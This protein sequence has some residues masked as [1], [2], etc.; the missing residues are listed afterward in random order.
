MKT[1]HRSLSQVHHTHPEHRPKPVEKIWR[2]YVKYAQQGQNLKI[3]AK[4][5]G[6]PQQTFS[7]KKRNG[8]LVDYL[9][10]EQKIKG[11]TYAFWILP[12]TCLFE[13]DFLSSIGHKTYEEILRQY[14]SQTTPTKP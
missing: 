11:R 7:L 14:L 9:R 12:D 10:F 2:K 6:N 5:K 13:H 4:I 3:K 1:E 8:A